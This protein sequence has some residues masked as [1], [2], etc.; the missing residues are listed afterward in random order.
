MN[1]IVVYESHWG[2]TATVARAVAEGIGS[3]VRALDTDAANTIDLSGVKLIVAGAPVIAF[4]LASDGMRK[5][6]AGD[7]KAP[8]PPD[9]SHPLMRAW[10]DGLP[11][12]QGWGAAFETRIWWSPRGATGTI[13]SKLKRAGYAKLARA[14]RFIVAGSYGPMREGELERSRSWGRSLAEALAA[15]GAET[16]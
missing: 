12:G 4:R 8:V 10:L 9:V 3:D 7:T 1:A 13:E 15:K 6:I 11:S 5:Q 16:A 14:E 2:N